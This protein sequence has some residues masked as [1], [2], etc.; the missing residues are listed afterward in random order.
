MGDLDWLPGF[1]FG[2]SQSCYSHL[3]SE[4]VMGNPYSPLLSFSVCL[5]LL[6]KQ[7]FKSYTLKKYN[8]QNVLSDML[9]FLKIFSAQNQFQNIF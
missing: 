1:G 6:F 5:S 3:G 8:V 7:K 9:I 2:L 4:P